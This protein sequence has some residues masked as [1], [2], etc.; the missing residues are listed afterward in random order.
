MSLVLS[1][2]SCGMALTTTSPEGVP[3][4]LYVNELTLSLMTNFTLN[5]TSALVHQE[6]AMF[7]H[8]PKEPL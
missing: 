6:K 1:I 2:L 3:P 5:D 8:R 7:L 4:Q